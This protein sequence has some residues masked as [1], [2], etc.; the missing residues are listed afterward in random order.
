[1]GNASPLLAPY[2][3]PLFGAVFYWLGYFDGRWPVCAVRFAAGAPAEL[4]NRRFPGA[5]EL[6]SRAG[7]GS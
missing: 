7:L 2:K 3:R 5:L 1:M 6:F 4:V